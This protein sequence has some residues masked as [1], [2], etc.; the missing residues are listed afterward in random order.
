MSGWFMSKKS[1]TYNNSKFNN[2]HLKTIYLGKVIC[3]HFA[4]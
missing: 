4:F 3:I 1:N 2:S